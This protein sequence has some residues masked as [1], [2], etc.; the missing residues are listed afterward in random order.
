MPRV[1]PEVSPEWASA[2]RGIR[3]GRLTDG[4]D[5]T[6]RFTPADARWAL[7]ALIGESRN[8]LDQ[9]A[10]LWT[11]AHRL[12]DARVDAELVG[13]G[14][15][16]Y[17]YSYYGQLRIYS[18][19]VNEYWE[20]RGSEEVIRNR[21]RLQSMSLE[22]FPEA[23]LDLVDRFMSGR[24]VMRSEFAGLTHFAAC[25]C[26]PGCGREGHGPETLKI[27]NCFWRSASWPRGLVLRG[28]GP[29]PAVKRSR[30]SIAVPLVLGAVGGALV[31]AG[32]KQLS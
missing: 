11:M 31:L 5:W 7:P 20:T 28:L 30:S 27:D 13:R 2:L 12:Y 26:T 4:G 23:T 22:D 19:P 17:A 32:W 6:Y 15:Y 24:L 1:G 10:I 25:D 18:A 3:L 16:A 9:E 14:G 29:R 8:I 21:A